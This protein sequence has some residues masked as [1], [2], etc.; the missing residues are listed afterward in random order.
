MTKQRKRFDTSFKLE[1]VR[2][3]QEQELGVQ[4]VSQSMVT[5]LSLDGA[6]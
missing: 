3:I 4:H 6:I 2:M 1:A 5:T